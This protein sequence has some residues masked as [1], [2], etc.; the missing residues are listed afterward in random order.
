[1]MRLVLLSSLAA[2]ACLSGCGEKPQTLGARKNGVAA[3]YGVE[4]PF[5]APGWKAGDKTSWE[6]ALKTRMLNS[7]NEYS[8]MTVPN[9]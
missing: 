7:Q 2:A 6:Q 8:K 3:Y 1:M 5:M 9:K 4:N